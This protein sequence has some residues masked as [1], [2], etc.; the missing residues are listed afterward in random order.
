MSIK[1]V[2]LAELN[3]SAY[4]PRTADPKRLDLIELSLCGVQRPIVEGQLGGESY[5]WFK[6]GDFAG[7][8]IER[9]A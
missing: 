5:L 6:F 7:W 2:P 3:P 4:N 8:V 9:P 1:L